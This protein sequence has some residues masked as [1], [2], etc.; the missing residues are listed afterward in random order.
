M[1]KAADRTGERPGHAVEGVCHAGEVCD[2]APECQEGSAEPGTVLI[3]PPLKD[4][5]E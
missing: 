4:L 3:S 2:R 5:T 1:A